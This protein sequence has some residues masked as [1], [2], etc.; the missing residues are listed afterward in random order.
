[1]KYGTEGS[2]F[3]FEDGTVFLHGEIFQTGV[4]LENIRFDE[5]GNIVGYGGGDQ[6]Y[7]SKYT[8]PVEP[9]DTNYLSEE[10]DPHEKQKIYETLE[11]NILIYYA[12][13]ALYPDDTMPMIRALDKRDPEKAIELTKAIFEKKKSGWDEWLYIDARKFLIEKGWIPERVTDFLYENG[14]SSDEIVELDEFMK[15]YCK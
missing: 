12:D 3:T 2:T 13:Y 11:T 14:W 15:K 7:G 1:M 4:K 10:E 6:W 5:S 9:P 8:P